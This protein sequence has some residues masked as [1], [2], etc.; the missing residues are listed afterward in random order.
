MRMCASL[1]LFQDGD[2]E[3]DLPAGGVAAAASTLV[4]FRECNGHEN[5]VCVPEVSMPYNLAILG[6]G[7]AAAYYLS[8]VDLN[9]FPKIIVIGQDDPWEGQR[10]GNADDADDPANFINQTAQMIAKYGDTVPA[11]STDLYPRSAWAKSNNYVFDKC[12]VDLVKGQILKVRETTTPE[13]YKAAL[14][15]ADKCFEV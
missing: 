12:K 13:R 1:M 11:Y 7:S 8:T 4:T 15:N 14:D 6:R 5:I 3:F 10:G 9:Q 2:G